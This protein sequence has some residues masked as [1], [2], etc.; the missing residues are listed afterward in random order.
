MG[1]LSE[2]QAGVAARRPTAGS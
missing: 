1:N 2:W